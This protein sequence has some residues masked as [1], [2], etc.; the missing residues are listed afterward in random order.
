MQT[1]P[2]GRA[3]IAREEAC[4]LSAYKDAVGVLTIAIGHTSAAGPPVVTPGMW[5]TLEECFEVFA[6]DLR[7]YEE[8]VTKAV[9]APLTQNQFD[10]LVS[11]CY[12]IGPG[13]FAKSTLVKKLNARDYLG[14]AD[15]FRV[16]NKAGGKVLKGL[17]ARRER[18]RNIFISGNYG[19]L[20]GLNVYDKY[21]GKAKRVPFPFAM[22]AAPAPQPSPPAAVPPPPVIDAHPVGEASP[23]PPQPGLW[24]RVAAFFARLFASRT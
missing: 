19:D 14:A 16:W 2:K 7:K 22:D 4:V 20:S 3:A 15:Q 11:L 10:A 21:P 6:R 5:L 9:T 1:S 8:P 12:N 18:E 17:T 13:N 23:E 24:A